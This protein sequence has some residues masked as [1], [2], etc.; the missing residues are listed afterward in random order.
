MKTT[1]G[2]GIPLAFGLLFFELR[3]LGK[4]APEF[5]C[6]WVVSFCALVCVSEPLQQQQRAENN[7]NIIVR[8]VITCLSVFS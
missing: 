2:I 4:S 1:T 5:V 3:L 7:N 8:K 6:V